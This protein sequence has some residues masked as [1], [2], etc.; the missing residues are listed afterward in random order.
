ME[1]HHAI[2]GKITI[3]N[4]KIHY[5]WPFSI[6]FCMFTRGYLPLEWRKIAL[7]FKWSAVSGRLVGGDSQATAPQII[8]HQ[9]FSSRFSLPSP[10]SWHMATEKK[11]RYQQRW[12]NHWSTRLMFHW[13]VQIARFKIVGVTAGH[14]FF[15]VT[16]WWT[17]IAME[18]HHF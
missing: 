5:K 7:F 9:R 8:Q 11:G 15:E 18:N 17:N 4:G 16:L 14:V 1:N 6:A 13:T 3:F 2:N 12:E 10:R